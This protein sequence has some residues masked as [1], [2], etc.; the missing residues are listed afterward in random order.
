MNLVISSIF[1]VTSF[2]IT[3]GISIGLCA[4]ALIVE[5][6]EGLIDRTW[7]AGVNAAE[8]VIAQ[9]FTQFFILVVQIT[10]LLVVV[11]FGFKVGSFVCVV[12]CMCC[13]CERLYMSCGMHFG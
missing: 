2:S 11:I 1:P 12:V 7:V 5:R 4:M 8:I 3:F 9:V 10:L 13:V 6:N